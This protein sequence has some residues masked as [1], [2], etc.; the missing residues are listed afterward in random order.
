MSNTTEPRKNGCF[1]RKP[2]A[3]TQ[4]IGHRLALYGETLVNHRVEIPN[5]TAADSSCQYTKS[6]L[7]RID[8]G[9]LCCKWRAS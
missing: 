8:A 5:F 2:F 7:G 1:D 6:N 4:T 9:C 3:P